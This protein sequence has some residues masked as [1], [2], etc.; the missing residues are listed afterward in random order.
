MKQIV[1]LLFACAFAAC[2][3]VNP[4]VTQPQLVSQH[5]TVPKSLYKSTFKGMPYETSGSSST[6]FTSAEFVQPLSDF[7]PQSLAKGGPKRAETTAAL[8]KKKDGQPKPDPSTGKAD[9]STPAGPVRKQVY[10]VNKGMHVPFTYSYDTTAQVTQVGDCQTMTATFNCTSTS[11]MNADY[12]NQG[13]HIYPSAIYDLTDFQN[14]SYNEITKD[15]QPVT[16]STDNPNIKGPSFLTVDSPNMITLREGVKTLYTGFDDSRSGT[17]DFRYQILVSHN[18]VEHQMKV[19]AGGGGSFGPFSA[20][21]ESTENST[22]N[23]TATYITVDVVK[24]MFTINSF[25]NDGYFKS[26]DDTKSPVVIKS[27]T[28]GLRLLANIDITGHES[29]VQ[30]TLSTKAKASFVFSANGHLDLASL[31]KVLDSNS[32]VNCY[33]VGGPIGSTCSFALKDFQD[34]IAKIVGGATANNARAIQYTLSDLNGNELAI[35][36]AVTSLTQQVCNPDFNKLEYATIDIITGGDDKDR[37]IDVTYG[38]YS[39]SAVDPN[40]INNTTCI[41]QMPT[42]SDNDFLAFPNGP[43]D[44]GFTAAGDLIGISSSCFRSYYDN[45]SFTTNR[46]RLFPSKTDAFAQL[47][48]AGGTIIIKRNY[49]DNNWKVASVNLHLK[50]TSDN[51]EKIMVW[52]LN[53]IELKKG[54]TKVLKFDQNFLPR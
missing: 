11:F 2:I 1:A 14:G 42:L 27:V 5:D 33:V 13:Q 50:F 29:Q 46:F 9:G 51:R 23:S 44:R 16:L 17:M 48:M 47:K 26:A 24:D 22:T 8:Q 54:D 18:S 38:L 43:N 10:Q 3:T 39:G 21:M 36:S 6:T 49:N 45:N 30:S 28:Y 34:N 7:D 32:R 4:V 19:S 35:Q 37:G 15:R 20:S 40:K 12:E 31:D 41:E 52:N 25:P 53:N